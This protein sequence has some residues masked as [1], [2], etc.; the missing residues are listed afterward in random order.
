MRHLDSLE[1]FTPNYFLLRQPC[2]TFPSLRFEE[3]FNH[4]RLFVRAQ[5]YTNAIWPQWLADFMPG[6]N[7]RVKWHSSPKRKLKTVNLVWK[8][9]I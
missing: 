3:E 7:K 1:A 9:V 4:S 2:A 8:V 6:L 5:A